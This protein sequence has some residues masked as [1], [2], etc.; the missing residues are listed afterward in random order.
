MSRL[1]LR[2]TLWACHWA[3]KHTDGPRTGPKMKH[4]HM[5]GLVEM[6]QTATLNVPR[7]K[8]ACICRDKLGLILWTSPII[9]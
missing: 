4:P 2:E 6:P 5:L 8:K 1:R 3:D 7:W 9:S